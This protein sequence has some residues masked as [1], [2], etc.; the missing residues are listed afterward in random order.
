MRNFPRI[1]LSIVLLLVLGVAADCKMRR[2]AKSSPTQATSSPAQSGWLTDYKQAQQQAKANG[3]LLLLNF[4]GSD[5]C[6]FCI[7]M[8]REIFSQPRFKEYADKNLV[9][10][11]VDFPR[12]KS[13]S[14]AVKMQNGE[15][16]EK[17]QIEGYPTIIVLNSDGK[18]VGEFGY[19]PGELEAF[20]AELKKLRNG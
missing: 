18:K 3:K 14:D 11:E 7:L 1:S 12:R 19:R 9:L 2:S 13:Q 17:Y 8:D 15:L 4:T 6:G 10:M 16:A 20:M 5:W